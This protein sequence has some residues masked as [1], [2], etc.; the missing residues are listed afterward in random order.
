M[1]QIARVRLSPRLQ[2][3]ADM[4]R[5][6]VRV[7]DIGT[8]HAYIP[9]YLL[10]NGICTEAVAVDLREK[11]LANARATVQAFELEN[12]INLRL[13]DG[14]DSIESGEAADIVLAGMG[15][16]LITDII[17]RANWLYDKSKQLIIQ[18]MTHAETVREFLCRRGFRILFENACM[19]GGKCYLALCARYDDGKPDSCHSL[20]YYHLGELPLCGNAA[21]AEY[22]NRLYKRLKKRADALDSSGSDSL[23]TAQL[24]EVLI[25]ISEVLNEPINSRQT[26]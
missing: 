25:K 20:S 12:T 6:G 2:M 7:A 21:A 26:L 8:D 16:D 14:L 13:S 11:P 23:E 24:K 17:G 9:V 10:Q 1:N 3:V 5:K 4:V 15:G 22:L 19:E 18:P